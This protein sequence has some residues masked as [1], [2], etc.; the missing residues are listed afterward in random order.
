MLPPPWRPPQ[1]PASERRRSS[2]KRFSLEMIFRNDS[3]ASRVVQ[4]PLSKIFRLTRRANQRYQLAPSF[5]GKR[6]VGDRHERGRG[7][8]GRGSV[9]AQGGRRAVLSR[10]RERATRAQDERRCCVRQ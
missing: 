10:T 5:P 9:G 7:C 8:G 2:K 6:G 4:S 3:K 1:S